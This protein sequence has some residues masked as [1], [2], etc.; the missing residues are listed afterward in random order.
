MPRAVDRNQVKEL[1]AAGARLVEVLPSKEYA[2]AH[3]P[4]A[5]NIPLTKLNRKSVAGW[6]EN[7]PIIVYCYDYQ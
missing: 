3:L 6:S 2:R 4:G 5:I 1:A 7:E